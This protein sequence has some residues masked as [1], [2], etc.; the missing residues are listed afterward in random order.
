MD[1][2]RLKKEFKEKCK[3]EKSLC[4]TYSLAGTIIALVGFIIVMSTLF[5]DSNM[6]IFEF[7]EQIKF[8]IAGAII[9]ICGGIFDVIGEIKFNKELKEYLRQKNL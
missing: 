2:K 8:Y 5:L 4:Y 7:P 9:S 1:K 6:G 3:K